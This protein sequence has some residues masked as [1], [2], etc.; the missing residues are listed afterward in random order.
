M[1]TLSRFHVPQMDCAAEEQMV[2][3]ALDGMEGIQA[4]RFDLPA[5]RLA[6]HHEGKA[7]PLADR[8]ATLGLGAALEASE[9]T[10]GNATTP[11]HGDGRMS[12]AW[13]LFHVTAKAVCTCGRVGFSRPTT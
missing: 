4:L 3:D 1:T 6:V 2:R 10:A 9:E 11:A 5:R 8:L 12:H 13:R 7:G